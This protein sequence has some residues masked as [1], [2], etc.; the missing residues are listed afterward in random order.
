MGQQ[1]PSVLELSVPEF[2]RPR[3]AW[4]LLVPLVACLIV[5]QVAGPA[6]ARG[7]EPDAAV[8]SGDTVVGELV[9]AWPE[10]RDPEDP[11]APAA[12]GPLTWVETDGGDAVRIPTESIAD[13]AR[14]E[15]GAT[16]EVV[17]GEQ[18]VDQATAEDGVEPAR[19]V[20][21]AA[22]VEAAPAAA[23][24]PTA[25]AGVVTTSVTLVMVVPAGGVSD[26]RPAQDVAAEVDGTVSSYWAG[27][28]DGRIRVG[29]TATH[30]LRSRPLAA[31]CTQPHELWNEVAGRI[32][33][34]RGAGEHLLVHL[35]AGSQSC[36]DGLAE[37][38]SSVSGGGRLYVRDVPDAVSVLGTIVAH[39]L[40]HNFGL[41]HASA[42]Q[43]D[44][45]V[46]TGT[47][48]VRAYYD[49]YDVMGI[50]WNELGSLNAPHAA[51]LGLLP[52]AERVALTTATPSAT[53]ALA[54]M[55][56]TSG[57]RAVRLAAPDGTVSWLE[58]RQGTGQDA[59]LGSGRNYP[60]LDSGVT[61]RQAS[62]DPSYTSLLL[63]G[64]PSPAAGWQDDLKVA[65]PVGA[66]VR[67]GGGVFTVTVRSVGA[68]ASVQV[69]T[70]TP[71]A[72]TAPKPAPTPAPTPAPA[73][74]PAPKP[75][76]VPASANGAARLTTGQVLTDGQALVASNKR[77]R[78]VAQADGNLVVYA[79]DRRVVWAS[80]AYAQ[81][82]RLTLQGD[83]NL[84]SRARD[85]RTSWSSRTAGSKA[86]RLV[87]WPDGSL[88]L[89]RADGKAVWATGR[90][91]PDRL[92]PGQQLAGDQAL[93]S[94]NGRYRAVAQSDG[95]VVV[96]AGRRVLWASGTYGKD[97]RL[98]LQGDGNLVLYAR[99]GRAAWSTGT[100]R[101]AGATAQLR[102]DGRLT[103]RRADGKTV[104]ATRADPRR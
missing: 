19:E 90:D 20:L 13:V 76:P 56:A 81:G 35:P 16:V 85:G 30:D 7:E 22:V 60:G 71:A 67:V 28:S 44:R 94:S 15:V 21:E 52:T 74:A 25:A 87:L 104:W 92:R 48:Q 72:T 6:L 41:N 10:H 18:V 68:T 103:V 102:D 82:S 43:C 9:Q 63:D 77:Y 83:G 45:A 66:P 73:P 27:Q 69:T 14:A 55:A 23:A 38:G 53:Y 98:V 42:R 54:P 37:I 97:T 80:G 64:T 40:G 61:L 12:D 3:P 47:C 17:V 101:Y 57:T 99:D 51:K 96:Y 2:C 49:W 8:G 5:G 11:A 33:W 32:G 46:E 39:E 70:P 91:T 36:A 4:S 62:D 50:S 88:A 79:A 1:I 26:R 34:T 75:A 29:V 84:V 65:L 93:V 58:Y 89:H 95:N 31:A 78:A 100:W 86:V 59:W 24:L